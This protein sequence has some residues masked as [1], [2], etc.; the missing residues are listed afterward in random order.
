M[1]HVEVVRVKCRRLTW[2]THLLSFASS[3]CDKVLWE[4]V[5]CDDVSLE[6]VASNLFQAMANITHLF[7]QMTNISSLFQAAA[8]EQHFLQHFQNP[9]HVF[10]A[11]RNITSSLEIGENIVNIF[12]IAQNV[13]TTLLEMANM[14]DIFS[15]SENSDNPLQITITEL[16]QMFPLQNLTNILESIGIGAEFVITEGINFLDSD[17]PD[18]VGAAAENVP[19]LVSSALEDFNNIFPNFF[20]EARFITIRFKL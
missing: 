14:A 3:F 20:G 4:R 2:L 18:I 10:E 15:E 6:S 9:V 17:F 8:N 13:T 7:P 19:D 16:S 12:Q 5:S 1:S 11:V